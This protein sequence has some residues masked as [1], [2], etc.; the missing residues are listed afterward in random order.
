MLTGE[1]ALLML[2]CPCLQAGVLLWAGAAK[3]AGKRVGVRYIQACPGNDKRVL[4]C[5]SASTEHTSRKVLAHVSPGV[6]LSCQVLDRR[7]CTSPLPLTPTQCSHLGATATAS[8]SL[9][10]QQNA[11]SSSSRPPV[12]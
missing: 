6:V 4:N 10:T 3:V 8:E 2:R 7:P 5:V 11:K 9:C 1:A 12:C